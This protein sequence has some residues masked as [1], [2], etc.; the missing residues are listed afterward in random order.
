MSKWHDA[1][2]NDALFSLHVGPYQAAYRHLR[3]LRPL[4]P[5]MWMSL[6][7][8][9]IAWTNS[10]TKSITVPTRQTEVNKVYKAYLERPKTQEH[11]AFLDWLRMY[12]GNKTP[13]KLY[14]QGTITL[15]GTKMRSV[16]ADDFFHQYN[17]LHIAHRKPDDLYHP[18]D[19]TLPGPIKCFAAAWLLSPDLRNDTE[20]VREYFSLHGNK[21]EYVMNVVQHVRSRIDFIHLWQ[22]RVVG[23][24]GQY[25]Q[26]IEE[27]T[28]LSPEQQRILAMIRQ[29]MEDRKQC[30]ED[31]PERQQEHLWDSDSSDEAVEQDAQR[32][33]RT[34]SGQQEDVD[35]GGRT[36]SSEQEDADGGAPRS[37]SSEDWKKFILINGKPGT[38]KTYALCKGVRITLEQ[39]YTVNLAAPTG[40]LASTYRGK[41]TEDNFSADTIHAL[42]K[43]PV[44][45]AERPRINWQL[46]NTD[47]LVIDEISMVP[48]K[49]FQHI[50]NTIQQL[51]IRP[52]VLLCGDSQQQQPIET[53]DGK[54]QAASSILQ[55]KDF[56][57]VC[58]RVN[59]VTQHR[60]QDP[61]Y[62][63]IL[64]TLRYYK[65]N[66]GLL[67]RLEAD[68][69]IFHKTDISDREIRKV[70]VD[71]PEAQVLTVS[72]KSTNRVNNIA[73]SL[74]ETEAYFGEV[75]Y[76]SDLAKA[77]LYRGLKV[78][79]T[80][81]RDKQNGVVNGQPAT[82]LHREGASIFLLHPK[83]YI[84]CV[85]PVTLIDQAGN[86]K[87]VYP[88]TP[89]YSSTITK[90]QGQNMKKV[91]LWLD[92]EK[93]P[94]GGAYVALS[95][96][97]KHEDLL[98]M[99]KTSVQQY[100][101]VE[102]DPTE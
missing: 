92:C 11:I 96:I 19:A 37:S 53:V 15:V 54:V 43:Y 45:P 72:S 26:E 97:R 98:F 2:S 61:Q 66:Q 41:F 4:E 34:S 9:K 75:A 68:R 14:K 29:A 67:D 95:R 78:V 91:I 6:S 60:C 56:Y 76:D 39:E 89:A 100:L 64:D 31:I 44:D 65:P 10:R 81:N 99:H 52:V 101:P 25:Q 80:Q 90:I 47:L 82:V 83:G 84:C 71:Q 21:E 27:L 32:R 36:S 22:R 93:V 63:A 69:I 73:L 5:E 24:I 40:F 94:K 70:L 13:A 46:I 23:A 20:K 57:S 79:I 87:T 12:D 85:Y 48:L 17:V 55:H 102:L 77:P 74:F 7:S 35:G 59:F 62:A 28:E 16:F 1:Y 51:Y 30:Y 49:I 18:D 88:F 42:F 38:G 8:Q 33:A 50:M 58:K 3:A 86:R